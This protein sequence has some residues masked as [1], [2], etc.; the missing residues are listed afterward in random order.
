MLRLAEVT[1]SGLATGL[2]QVKDGRTRKGDRRFVME[3]LEADTQTRRLGTGSKVLRVVTSVMLFA[4]ALPFPYGYYLLLR[5][6]VCPVAAFAAIKAFRADREGWGWT[7]GVI[8]LLFNPLWLMSLGRPLW[9]LVDVVT[10]VI[11]TVS[12]WALRGPKA[13]GRAGGSSKVEST[14][15]REAR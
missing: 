1:R 12:I 4:A 6:V 7:L 11:L 9:V 15:Q 14:D 10:A 8:A 2:D 3:G 13:L 5:F